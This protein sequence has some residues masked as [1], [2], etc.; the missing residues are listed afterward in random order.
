MPRDYQGE[1]KAG[2]LV[3]YAASLVPIEKVHKLKSIS[4]V[5]ESF[6]SEVSARRPF[7]HC[8]LR[9]IADA[10]VYDLPCDLKL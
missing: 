3:S 7:F 10:S 8:Y 1:R 2:G 4:E 9:P 6:L 5:K